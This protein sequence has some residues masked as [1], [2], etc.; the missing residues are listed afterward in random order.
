M[1]DAMRDKRLAAFRDGTVNLLIATSVAEEAL[2]VA[3]CSLGVVFARHVTGRMR[4][5]CRGR[6]RYRGKGSEF[7]VICTTDEQVWS[8]L[9]AQEGERHMDAALLPAKRSA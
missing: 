1:T 3:A 2:D 9:A 6:V 8:N 5:Q 7:V 4:L